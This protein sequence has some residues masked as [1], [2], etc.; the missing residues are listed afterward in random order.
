LREC[1]ALEILD[2][3]NNQIEY[4]ENI[5]PTMSEIKTLKV[6]KLVDNECTRKFKM[7]RKTIVGH[8]KELTYL[9]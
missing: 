2:L 1:K 4:D 8:C 5:L 7:Y 6:L 9:D 3:Q